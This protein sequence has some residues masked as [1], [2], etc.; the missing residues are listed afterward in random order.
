GCTPSY[1]NPG[2]TGDRTTSI[3]VTAMG[4]AQG[5]SGDLITGGTLDHFVNGNT[6]D[7]VIFF[8]H[9]DFDDLEAN[10]PWWI[11]FDFGSPAVINAAKYY[12]Q[13]STD[14]GIWKW[15]GSNDASAWTDIG[16]TFSLV[17][18]STTTLTT[19][20]ANTTAYRYYRILAVSG[21][22]SNGPFIYEFEFQ[23]C[24]P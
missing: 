24:T 22:T 13:T 8:N 4:T 18:A 17:T 11:Q 20:S 23:I 3:T 9:V 14:Q 2:G 19:L 6:A 16:S 5:N 10:Q 15:Q 21:S 12:Q 7:N 1:A